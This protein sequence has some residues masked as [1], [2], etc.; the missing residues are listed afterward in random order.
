MSRGVSSRQCFNNLCGGT[1]QIYVYTTA[2]TYSIYAQ[3]RLT[4]RQCTVLV[5][6]RFS[7]W[8]QAVYMQ[9][10][11][12]SRTD[13][14]SGG[15]YILA[16]PYQPT[17]CMY[18]PYQYY[19]RHQSPRLRRYS[20]LAPPAWLSLSG[21]SWFFGKPIYV[22]CSGNILGVDLSIGA[23]PLQLIRPQVILQDGVYTI[24]NLHH[25]VSRPRQPV[26]LMPCKVWLA[27]ILQTAT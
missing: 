20:A 12:T 25:V 7:G 27:R 23:A 19:I 15:L 14:R 10:D 2:T 16:M 8:V 1:R 13:K 5:G 17:L 24:Y 26:D 3:R 4:A 21:Q 11:R 6:T 9:I 18:I 22:H